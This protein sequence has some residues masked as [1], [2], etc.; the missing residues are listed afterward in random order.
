MVKRTKSRS[1]RTTRGGKI[2]AM[3]NEAKHKFK[4]TAQGKSR[5][6]RINNKHKRRQQKVNKGNGKIMYRGQGKW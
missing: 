1:Q 2:K 3:R 6:T 5:N 4:R